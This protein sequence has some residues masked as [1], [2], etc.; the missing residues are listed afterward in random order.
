MSTPA[1][2]RVVADFKAESTGDK[3]IRLKDLRGQNVVIYFY[4]KDSRTELSAD[5]APDTCFASYANAERR[6]RAA[7]R[8]A[9]PPPHR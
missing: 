9:E 7:D 4:P 3:T 6:R 2:N 1:M 5:T 8:V